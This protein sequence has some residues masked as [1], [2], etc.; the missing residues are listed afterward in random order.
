M[1]WNDGDISN[2]DS[3]YG[4]ETTD[5]ENGFDEKLYSSWLGNGYGFPTGD[6]TYKNFKTNNKKYK[7]QFHLYHSARQKFVL[8]LSY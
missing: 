2:L 4:Q 8:N 5:Y 7:N 3:I 6:G 1:H